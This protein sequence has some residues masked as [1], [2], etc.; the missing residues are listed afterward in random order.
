M[1]VE[2]DDYFF[3][4]NETTEGGARILRGYGSSPFVVIP[5]VVEG[6]PVTELADYCFADSARAASC[7]EKISPHKRE[8]FGDYIQRVVIPDSVKKLGDL[9][10]YNCRQLREI[11]LG[12]GLRSIG[13]DAFMNCTSLEKLTIRSSFLAPTGLKQL[14]DRWSGDVQVEFCGQAGVEGALFFPEYYEVHDLIGPAHIFALNIT[15]EGF[16]ARQCVRDG[17][18]D[19]PQYDAVFTQACAEESEQTLCRMAVDRLR[20]PVALTE[21]ARK[22]YEGYL[23][24]HDRTLM[25]IL[26]DSRDL[27]G[28]EQIASLSLLSGQGIEEGIRL[29]AECAWAEGAAWMLGWQQSKRAEAGKRRYLFED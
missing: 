3:C 20:Y 24:E 19:L 23:R 15:G 21:G 5:D 25:R 7:Q 17:V 12:A 14:L 11:E 22:I 9:V 13:S 18:V 10:F 16:R 26:I 1:D 29:A 27:E 6:L 4:W 28:I 8:L 2:M